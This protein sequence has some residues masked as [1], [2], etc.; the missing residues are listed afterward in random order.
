MGG[1]IGFLVRTFGLTC[2]AV[3]SITFLNAD[4]EII[5]VD[6][7]TM[8]IFFG[9]CAA[10]V[11]DLTALYWDGNFI[12]FI[13]PMQLTM[14]LSWDW[15][16]EILC[17]I[18]LAWQDWVENLPP[19]I[20]SVLSVTHPNNPCADPHDCPPTQEIRIA[21]LKLF[22]SIYRMEKAFSKVRAPNSEIIQGGYGDLTKYWVG[23]SSLPFVKSKS[24][25][26]FEPVKENTIDLVISL[27]EE[28]KNIDPLVLVNFQF[29]AFGGVLPSKETAFFPRKAFGWWHQAYQWAEQ[30]Q[31]AKVLSLS[32]AFY[33]EIPK[34]VS[35]YCYSN[36]VDYDI[37][38]FLDKYYGDHVDRLIKNKNKI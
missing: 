8:P 27:F 4:A 15:N 38:C 3:K 19:Q 26:L 1:G 11:M 18:M 22:R 36:S 2:D 34:D 30:H 24:R 29:E 31:S 16:P 10:A 20:S 37:D 35:P 12:C 5:E 9:P 23:Q 14:N 25:I 21:G 6:A 28:L 17:P 32:R 33:A 13:F 7:T